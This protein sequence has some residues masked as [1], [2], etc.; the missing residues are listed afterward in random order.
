MKKELARKRLFKALDDAML[1]YG[2][3]AGLVNPGFCPWYSD[4]DIMGAMRPTRYTIFRFDDNR[5][6]Y[7]MYETKTDTSISVFF[8]HY[9]NPIAR[10]HIGYPKTEDEAKEIVKFMKGD[11]Q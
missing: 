11:E 4:Y 9:E 6:L 8:S 10:A 1:K 3:D 2:Q 7:T 5:V